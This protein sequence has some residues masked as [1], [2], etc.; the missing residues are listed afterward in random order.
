MLNPNAVT[1]T[2]IHNNYNVLAADRFTPRDPY[3]AK[4]Q[5]SSQHSSVRQ[6]DVSDVV[7]LLM[8]DGSS[9]TGQISKTTHLKNG[10]GTQTWPDGARYI[11]E[12]RQGQA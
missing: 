1:N 5:H 6:S 9:Y 7:D 8:P 11:G 10:Y 4:K 12:W 3:D 2:F